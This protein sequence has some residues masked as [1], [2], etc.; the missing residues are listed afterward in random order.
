MKVPCKKKNVYIYIFTV[1]CKLAISL[2]QGKTA[3]RGKRSEVLWS[4]D[5]REEV[6][7]G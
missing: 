6:K 3:Q 7:A 1:I 5:Q 4:S 2:R